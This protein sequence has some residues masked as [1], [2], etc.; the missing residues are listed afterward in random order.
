MNDIF[1]HIPL[2]RYLIFCNETTL[3]RTVLDCGAGG[4]SPSLGL[5]AQYGYATCGVE[6]DPVAIEQARA[7][8]MENSIFSRGI[9]GNCLL[10][11]NPSVLSI[12]IIPSSI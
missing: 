11:M 5:F 4:D 8:E 10:K 9:C 6:Y 1:K 2:Y 3:D 7:Y 12:P